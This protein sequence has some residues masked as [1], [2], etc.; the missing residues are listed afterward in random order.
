MQSYAAKYI[1]LSRFAPCMI[2]IEYEKAQSFEKGLRKDIRRLIGMLQIREFSV[3]VE[4]S[5]VVEAG[6]WENEVAQDQKKR[7]ISSGS[8][9]GP[10][11]DPSR[12]G[13]AKFRKQHD[14]ECQPFMGNCYRYGKPSHASRNCPTLMT[15]TAAP[16]QNQGQNQVPRTAQEDVR[17]LPSGNSGKVAAG[18]LES[19]GVQ[20]S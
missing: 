15:S 11:G 20:T 3:L 6:L 4:K 5:A 8:Q 19:G 7:S 10:Q 17:E 16:S 9:T 12:V 18:N 2:L 1:E 14:G 13:C